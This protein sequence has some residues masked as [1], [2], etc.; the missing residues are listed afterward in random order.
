M[1]EI[2]PPRRGKRAR[3][4]G[5]L[6]TQQ[7]SDEGRVEAERGAVVTVAVR[8]V[9]ALLLAGIDAVGD[10]RVEQRFDAVGATPEPAAAHEDEC[11]APVYSAGWP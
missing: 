3:R 7:R 6:A 4:Q 8:V 2:D 1:L 5:R 9:A 11:V 10:R